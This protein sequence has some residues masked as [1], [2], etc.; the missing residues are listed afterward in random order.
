MPRISVAVS[1]SQTPGLPAALLLLAIPG[2]PCCNET[3]TFCDGEE[4]RTAL[5]VDELEPRE[6][7][8]ISP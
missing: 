2:F 5:L 7:C 3:S 1:Q 8:I 6:V 4:G